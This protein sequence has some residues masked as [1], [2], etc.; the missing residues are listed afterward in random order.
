MDIRAPSEDEFELAV[1]TIEAAFGGEPHEGDLERHQKTMP[2]DRILCAF[3]D[4]RPVGTAASFPFR[5]TIPG[6]ELPAAGVTW[7][8]VLPSHRRRGVMTQF[9]ERQLSE[10]RGRG[11]PLAILWA[12]ESAIYGRFGYGM[13]APS[14]TLDGERARFGFR[15]DPGPNGATR[16]VDA[17]EAA[18]LFPPVHDRVRK[19]VPGMFSLP[20]EWWTEWKLADPEHFRRGAGPKFF[21]AY[22]RDGAVEAYAVYRLK[23]EW[24]HGMPRGKLYVLGAHAVTPT[25]TRELWRFL[26]GIDLVERVQM[27]LFDPGSSL[28][29]MVLDP[30]SLHLVVG[31]GLWLRLVDVEAALRGRTY[32]GDGAVVIGVRD[33]L[34]PWN[35]GRYRVGADVARTDDEADIE[36]D[37]A[38]LACAYLGAFDF[39]ALVRADRAR[40]LRPGALDEAS[41]L[42]RTSRPPFCADEF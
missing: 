10:V 11:E 15:D 37:V 1:K 5:L 30:R 8:G 36:L 27:T 16:L 34:C 42:F 7:V 17:R 18:E 3:D 23:N 12:S 21:A 14:L 22:E 29:L 39:H 41:A 9:M 4:G 32:P 2:R 35:A 20:R 33:S 40:E 24:E 38:D 28:M 13:S 19:E 6:G 25:A 26:F 31:D